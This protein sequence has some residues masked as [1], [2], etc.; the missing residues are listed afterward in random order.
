M[1]NSSSTKNKIASRERT[2]AILGSELYFNIPINIFR[3]TNEL[4]RQHK[5]KLLYFGGEALN[6]PFCN[7]KQSNILYN[8]INPKITDGL[9]T[10]SNLLSS[11]ISPLEFRERCLQFYPLP[12]VSLGIAVEGIPSVVLDNASG[13]YEAIC[14][15]IEVH[16][17]SRIA[18]LSGP[19]E[20]PDTSERFSAFLNAMQ[21]HNLPVEE[22]LLLQGDYM[23]LSGREAVKELLDIRGK[24]PGRDVQAIVCCNDYMA[25]GVLLELDKRNIPIPD[26]IA[27]VGFDNVSFAEC[28]TPSLSTVCYPFETMA[29]KATELMMAMLEGESVQEIVHVNAHFIPRRSCG[30]EDAPRNNKSLSLPED[31]DILLKTAP[32]KFLKYLNQKIIVADDPTLMI[33]KEPIAYLSKKDKW[34]WQSETNDSARNFGKDVHSF[35]GAIAY[36]TF[37]GASYQNMI[38]DLGSELTS[39]MEIPKLLSIMTEM[40]SGAGIGRCCICLYENPQ[41]SSEILPDWSRLIMAFSKSGSLKLPPGGLRFATAQLLPDEIV[42]KQGWQSWV[43]IALYFDEEQLGYILIDSDAP[44]ENIYW[45]LRKQISGALKGDRLLNEIRKA[46]D[47]LIEANEQKTQ[48]FINVAHETKTPL[49]LIKNYLSLYMEQHPLDENLTIIKQNIDMLLDNMLNFLDVEKL[50][51]GDT[52]YQHDSL[53]DLSESARKK[54]V[55]FQVV[56]KKKNIRIIVNAASTI[57]IRIDPWALDRIFNNLLDNAVKYIQPGGKIT[58]DVFSADGKAVLQV[59][60]NGPGLPADTSEHIFEPYYLLSMK[61][62]SK[63]GVGVGLSI[64]KKIIDGMGASI[65]VDK[66]RG[67][68][69]CFT[70]LFTDST[71]VQDGEALHDIPATIPSCLVNTS[72][73]ERNI[74]TEKSSILIVDDNIQLLKFMQSSL[75]KTYNVFLAR[76]VPE[77]HFKL[78]TIPHPDLIIADIMMDG[79]DGFM[80][81]SDLAAMDGYNDIP[82]IFLTAMSDEKAKTK[83]LGLGAIDYIEKP[84]SIADLLAKIDSL[85]ALRKRQEK[86][87]IVHIKKGIERAFF[88]LE[89]NISGPTKQSFDSLCTKYGINGREPEIIQLLMSGLMHK[90]IA[91]RLNISLRGI[92]YHIVKIYKK[93]GVSNKYELFNKLQ[94]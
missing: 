91:A 26:K 36:N 6:S 92:E 87:D 18:F 66:C 60:D 32:H 59:S 58:L 35:L 82:F 85:I 78:K 67:G 45:N 2:I 81:L 46:Y 79:A 50:Q 9:I 39:T 56:A 5:Y 19:S 29:T 88:G 57:I 33:W 76:D 4:A 55:L 53:V 14:H 10:I 17:I 16:N 83:G 49:T 63:Q 37:N 51:K 20:H 13:M 8:M 93:C 73:K 90:E 70:I 24:I 65:T 86:Q 7:Y 41:N 12:V 42:M 69:T 22:S 31:M 77:A 89:Q 21:A 72:I 64:I 15:L 84:F 94:G 44:Y 75:E 27:L 80:L 40:L 34:D 30:C 74:T 62:T 61:K 38:H 11:Y 71:E 47:L 48:F 3:I 23:Q 25:S 1:K 54:C 28:V 43:I 68:G 52:I